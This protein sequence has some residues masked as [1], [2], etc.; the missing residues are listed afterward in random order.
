MWEKSPPKLLETLAI[1]R[2]NTVPA[3]CH[4]RLASAGDYAAL[5]EFW[6]RYFSISKNCQSAVPAAHI[7]KMSWEIIIV[8]RETGDIIGSIVRRKIKGLHVRE[9]RW[10]QAAVIDYFCIHPAWRSRGLGRSLLNAIHNTAKMPMSP[11]LI[12]WETIRLSVPPLA[13]GCFLSRHTPINN[14]LRI[15]DVEQCKKAWMKCVKG[16]DVW[17]ENY[18][19]EIS[20]WPCQGEVVAIWN[21]FHRSLPDGKPIGIILGYTANILNAFG[22]VGNGYFGVIAY[23]SINPFDLGDKWKYDS[24]FQWIG[25]NLSV[26]C[27]G[28]FPRIGF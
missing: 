2:Q 25:Y 17:T 18:G 21:T 15:T 16:A 9:A 7:Q 27:M 20:F 23:P 10:E 13:L 22:D 12:F 26:G 8:V 5:T 11:Q 3:G 24:T 14:T 4:L 19:E 6:S 1:K 28:S